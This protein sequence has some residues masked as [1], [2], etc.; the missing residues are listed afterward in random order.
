[1]GSRLTDMC[2]ALCKEVKGSLS[3][4]RKAQ[5]DVV[6]RLLG[7]LH[8]FIL[9]NIFLKEVFLNNIFKQGNYL[10]T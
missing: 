5:N 10:N 9:F 4:L 2:N 7:S 8:G 3:R 6:T 1:M